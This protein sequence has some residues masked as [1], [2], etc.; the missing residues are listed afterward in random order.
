MGQK[1]NEAQVGLAVIIAFVILIAGVLW[2]NQYRLRGDQADFA[3]DF[4]GVEGLQ[5]RDRVQV[6]GIRMG[7][8]DHFEMV[9][10]FVRVYFHV[11]PGADLR[12]DARFKLQTVGIVGEI[13][14][15]IDPGTGSPA[16]RGH[17]F[18]GEVAA[19]MTAVTGT[20]SDALADLRDLTQQ[21]RGLIEEIRADG[22]VPGTL[23]SARSAAGTLDTLL[24]ENRPSLRAVLDHFEA[25]ARALRAALA[26][27]DSALATTIEGASRTFSR[28][29]SVLANLQRATASLAEVAARLEAGQGSAGRLLADD[30][31][32]M[33]AD[34]TLAAVKELLSDVRRNPRKYFKFSVIDF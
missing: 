4:P 28:A 31:L 15:D 10:D 32:Y 33:R 16:P 12:T 7:S 24:Q 1:R 14:I 18:K 21:V 5:V 11:D 6:R 2:F 13:V 27:P 29:D 17:V 34:S 19:S 3:V 23:A 20:A 30:G 9:E 25:T 22:R 26:G 8:V